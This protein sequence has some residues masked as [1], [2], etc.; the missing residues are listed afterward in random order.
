M[1]RPSND[2]VTVYVAMGRMEAELVRGRLSAENIPSLLAYESVGQTFG[3]TID[4]LGQ[5]RVQVPSRFAEAAKELL[6][7]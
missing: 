5:V 6:S 7:D 3:L 2:L 4:G 1:S